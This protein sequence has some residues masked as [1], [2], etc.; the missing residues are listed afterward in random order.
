MHRSVKIT[1]S[2]V[3]MFASAVALALC[4]V[5]CS[6]PQTGALTFDPTLADD[7]VLMNDRDPAYNDAGFLEY[8]NIL[9]NQSDTRYTLSYTATFF[10][11]SMRPTD[12]Q[13]PQR[14]FLD[15]HGEKALQITTNNRKSRQVR[16]RVQL[17]K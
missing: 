12:E 9:Q 2:S 7:L 17:A 5:G 4:L 8:N 10:D 1:M 15:P 6:T 16:I 11:E 3:P 14:F 13:S